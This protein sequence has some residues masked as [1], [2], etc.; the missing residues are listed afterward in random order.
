MCV[1]FSVGGAGV[2]DAGLQTVTINRV[3]FVR[4]EPVVGNVNWASVD[5]EVRT[6]KMN[7]QS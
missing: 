4:F 1:W 7:Y 2:Y 3:N 5:Q 6:K